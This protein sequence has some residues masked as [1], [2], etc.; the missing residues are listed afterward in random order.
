MGIIYCFATAII[1]DRV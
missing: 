1:S